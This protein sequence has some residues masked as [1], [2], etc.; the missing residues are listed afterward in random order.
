MKTQTI[1]EKI[2]VIKQAIRD[3][4]AIVFGNY[5]SVKSQTIGDCNV[6][7]LKIKGDNVLCFDLDKDGE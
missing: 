6:I 3:G 4:V 1:E 7:P 2:K 5:Y